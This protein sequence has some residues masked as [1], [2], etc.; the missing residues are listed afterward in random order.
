MNAVPT[1]IVFLDTETLGLELMAPIWELAA[2]RVVYDTDGGVIETT[3][4]EFFVEHRPGDHLFKLPESF[5]VDYVTRYDPE[6]ALSWGS[7]REHLVNIFARDDFGNRPYL[8]GAV[9]DF[10]T[11]RLIA[12]KYAPE[13]PDTLW[14]Y[15]LADVENLAVGW[16]P[17]REINLPPWDSD[18][19]SLL[20]GV[21]PKQFVRH[22]AMEDVRWAR[23]IFEQVMGVNK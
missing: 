5:R 1:T 15:H 3:S 8:C 18:E 17:P 6:K 2:Q 22:Q 19:L 20:V 4:W 10:D 11:S 7:A 13:P 12:Q 14:H 23:A 21:D 16:T 9:P